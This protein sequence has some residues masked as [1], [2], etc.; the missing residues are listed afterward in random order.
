MSNKRQ[1]YINL[2]VLVGRKEDINIVTEMLNSVCKNDEC[3]YSVSSSSV[4]DNLFYIRIQCRRESLDELRNKI[5]LNLNKF[6]V[7]I[8]WY[9]IEVIEV[10]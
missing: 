7:K 4:L 1:K 6:D 2:F 3:V 5:A 9:K 10:K 8:S